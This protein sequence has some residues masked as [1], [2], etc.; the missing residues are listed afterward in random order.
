MQSF[1][2]HN[3]FAIIKVELIA[4]CFEG[5]QLFYLKEEGAYGTKSLERCT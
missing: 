5:N 2:K 4:N 3:A 1:G